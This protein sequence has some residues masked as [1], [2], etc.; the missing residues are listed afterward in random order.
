MAGQVLVGGN[1]LISSNGKFA[2]GFFQTGSSKSSDNTTLPNWYLGIWFNNISKFTTVWVANRDKPI[3]GPIFKLSELSVSRDGNLVILNKVANSMIW[4]S[5]IENRTKTSRNIIVVLSDNGNLVILD[6]SNPSNVWW[7]SFDHPTDVL[8]PGANIGQNKITGQKYSL[9]SKKNSE[10]PA[11]GL[12]CMELDPSGSKQFYDKLCNSSMVYFNTGEWNG[13][14]FNSVPEMGVNAFADPKIVDNDEEE[15]LTY[16][17]FDKTGFSVKSPRDWD[18]DDRREGCTRNIPVDCSGNKTTTGLTDK[19]FP[20]P[21]V[22]LP[23]DAHT[24][25]T[26]ASAHECMQQYNGTTNTNED[27]LYLRL[28]SAEVQSWG[29]SRSG[30]IIGVAVGAS[31]SVFNYLAFILLLMIWRSKRRSCDHRMNEIKEGA[32][33]VAFRYADLQR[34]TKNFSTKLGGGSFGSVFKGILNDSTTIAV[35]MLDGARQ[36]EKQ[37]RAEVSTIGM[38]QHVNLVKLIGFCC[39]GDRRMLVYEHMVNRSLDTHLFRSNGTILN[40]ST[41][42]QIAIG[43]AKGLSYLHQSCHDCIIHCDIKPENILLDTSF[44]PKVADFGMAK[45]LGRDFS[46]VLTTMRGTIGYLAPKWISGVAITQKVDVYSYGMVLLEIISGRRNTLDECKSTGDQVVYFPM[47]VA[48]KLIK[49]D[50]GSLVDHQLYGDMNMEEVE[51]ACKVACW[52]IQDDDFNRPTMGE[53]VQVLE[54]LVE[55][56]MPQ[57]P[58]LLQTILGG[59]AST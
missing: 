17:P 45:L 16:T 35:K 42:Y 48:R 52:C 54:G 4:S 7:Q 57:V 53:V 6:A 19:F 5:Q 50:V 31:V 49:G 32:G 25:E 55:P 12:Y 34:A 27:I 38:I 24:M 29:H 40:W 20:I 36:G 59:P 2:L 37:F 15:Y 9:T 39:E 43:V 26:V 13:R 51:R 41:R 11:L 1:K 30:K 8:L 58:R 10:D 56:D 21:S 47:Q 23:Y 18:L 14:Y 46:R 3:A 44:V 28:A 33:I 22:R